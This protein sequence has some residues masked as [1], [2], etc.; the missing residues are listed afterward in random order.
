MKC[1]Y[2]GCTEAARAK[3]W[4]LRHYAV[5]A[6]NHRVPFTRKH[7]DRWLARLNGLEADNQENQYLA[8]GIAQFRATLAKR[9]PAL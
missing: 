8:Q 5:M 2:E 9:E 3:G 7:W 1:H 6:Y 4:C